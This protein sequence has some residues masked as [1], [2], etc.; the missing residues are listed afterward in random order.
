MYAMQNTKVSYSEWGWVKQTLGNQAT[1]LWRLTPNFPTGQYG[2]LT[3]H[4]TI[5]QAESSSR[6]DLRNL[7]GP[8]KVT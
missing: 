5:C 1:T 3:P 2:P 4:A 8:L 6:Q 7:G